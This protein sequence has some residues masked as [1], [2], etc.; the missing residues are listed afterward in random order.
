MNSSMPGFPVLYYLP[1]FVHIHIHWVGDAI[2]LSHSVALFSCLQSFPASGSFPMQL[3]LHISGQ[4]TGVS[5][6]LVSVLQVNIQGWLPLRL[7]GLIP[8][9]SKRLSRVFSSTTVR[10]HQILGTQPSLWSNS[11]TL[12]VTIG[13]TIALTMQTFVGKVMSL[14]F[15]M[16]SRFVIAFL[17]RSKCHFISWLQSPSAVILE[18][19]KIKP[20]TVS[21]FL[22]SIC[23]E[24]M[25]LDAM[26][27]VFWMLSFKPDFSLSS[28]TFNQEAL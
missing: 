8:V 4:T 18:L 10:K 5:S 14:L 24:V 11:H 22:P 23:H 3:A 12:N 16:L 26:I 2:Q 1:E 17:P 13:K 20:V 25:G 21:T 6:A 28:F 7:T 27:L 19:K 15:N 9:L